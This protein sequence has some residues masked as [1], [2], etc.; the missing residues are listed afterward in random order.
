MC[1]GRDEAAAPPTDKDRLQSL[2][3]AGVD[4][5]DIEAVEIPFPDMG[6]ALEAGRV[7]AV[8]VTEPFVTINKLASGAVPVLSASAGQDPASP[9]SVIV[10][11]E[12]FI[13]KNKD[14]VD[15]FRAAVDE[16]NAYALAHDDEVRATLPTF[17]ELKPDLADTISLAPIDTTD[18][19][20]G[21]KSWAD[22]LVEVG[23]IKERPDVEAAFLAD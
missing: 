5:Q 10:S 23:A 15:D 14:L 2:L 4:P 11:A 20:D 3:D 8:L 22:L 1:G 18:D 19:L 6:T 12:A 16:A 17:T 13:G 7:D 21:W 9:Q